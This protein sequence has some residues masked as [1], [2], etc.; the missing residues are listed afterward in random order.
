MRQF[1]AAAA[2]TGATIIRFF[3][4]R[5]LCHYSFHLNR[6]PRDKRIYTSS[7]IWP[8]HC[9]ARDILWQCDVDLA[10]HWC[11]KKNRSES[12]EIFNLVQFR[13]LIECEN[14]K[15]SID[16][17]GSSS[18]SCSLVLADIRTNKRMNDKRRIRKKRRKKKKER[19]GMSR[20][21]VF[22]SSAPGTNEQEGHGGHNN[23]QILL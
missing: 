15:H 4:A 6:K 19:I 11:R 10:Q 20:S 8:D 13:K 7:S 1:E 3:H 2:T 22:S 18:S 21:R 14:Q 23:T 9:T 16:I 12:N 5:T 17:C